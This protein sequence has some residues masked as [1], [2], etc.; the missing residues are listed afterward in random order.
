MHVLVETQV[1]RILIDG[2]EE[3]RAVGVEY[4]PNPSFTE[5]GQPVEKRSVVARKLV[6][7]SA[8]SFGT[9]LLLE[10]SGVGDPEVLERAGVPV[11]ENLPGVGAKYQG[12]SDTSN[13][14]QNS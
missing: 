11:V 12:T 9:P 1:L 2:D 3:K 14:E 5:D 8:G 6:V 7:A 4:R 10:R 13:L